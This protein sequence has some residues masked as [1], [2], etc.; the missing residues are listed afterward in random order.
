MWRKVSLLAEY[1]WLEFRNFLFCP[2]EAEE[3][4]I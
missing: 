2:T 3:A 1:I 4:D